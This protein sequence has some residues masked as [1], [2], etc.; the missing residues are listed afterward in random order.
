MFQPKEV[1]DQPAATKTN[2]NDEVS[3]HADESANIDLYGDINM[4][5]ETVKNPNPND[6]FGITNSP[7]RLNRSD[8]ILDI[9]TN[10]EFEEPDLPESESD[11]A[12]N[13]Q[14]GN[15]DVFASM[16]EL[17]KWER[18]DDVAT[19]RGK[20]FSYT[21]TNKNKKNQLK[22]VFNSIGGYIAH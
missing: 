5:S 4:D 14:S 21:H 6:D 9:H 18:E 10:V 22:C 1:D 7:N 16:P 2:D 15:D 17:S 20:H 19:E 3:F 12:N 13:K 11:G 8:S